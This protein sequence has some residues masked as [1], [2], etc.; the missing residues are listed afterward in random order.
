MPGQLKLP[1]EWIDLGGFAGGKEVVGMN[2]DMKERK[3][4]KLQP[5]NIFTSLG[6]LMG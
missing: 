6:T 2:L 3:T 4:L 5:L 1:G